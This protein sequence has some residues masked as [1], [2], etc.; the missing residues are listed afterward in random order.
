MIT[1]EQY[2]QTIERDKTRYSGNERGYRL[3]LIPNI[4]LTESGNDSDAVEFDVV[5][6][7]DVT[8]TSS[9]TTYPLVNGDVVADHM[10]RQ[11][12]SLT[13]SG[14]FALLGSRTTNF[15]GSSN[16]R[17]RNI[18]DYFEN[19]KNSGTLCKLVVRSRVDG[20]E[21]FKERNCV[22]L[23][24]IRWGEFQSSLSFTFTFD[25]IM[26]INVEDFD[27]SNEEL[28][29][30]D[31]NIPAITDGVSRSF[32]DEVVSKVDVMISLLQTAISYGIM[33]QEFADKYINDSKLIDELD[34]SQFK[35]VGWS[36][37]TATIVGTAIGGAAIITAGLV[38]GAVVGGPVGFVVGLVGGII[39]AIAWAV[40]YGATQDVKYAQEQ[41]SLTL[42]DY[43]NSQL[44]DEFDA[45]ASEVFQEIDILN[46]FNQFF[47]F[48]SNEAQECL[49]TISNDYYVFVISKN[50]VTE[51]W[52][53]IIE[54]VEGNDVGG[55]KIVMK[56]KAL[57]GLDEVSESSHI[58][59]SRGEGAFIYLYVDKV[60][61]IKDNKALTERERN[62]QLEEAYKDITNYGIIVSAA[63]GTKSS[64][65]NIGDKIVQIVENSLKR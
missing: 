11:P 15:S 59:R 46:E 44:V 31:P 60:A 19:L 34:S 49:L 61:G 41:F 26:L 48:T 64:L 35:D 43:K 42:D 57:P 32:T 36:Q 7:I 5:D 38:T 24:S 2:Y 52:E 51:D 65:L 8:S 37:Y 22:V 54:D 39:G 4:N 1:E 23:K 63:D 40:G 47:R 28:W 21:R 12:V 45:F 27:S 10:I 9:I 58:L 16:D 25:E 13:V 33:T 6:S 55:G 3:V 50:N 18:Q 56:S 30:I 62:I 14:K 29:N 53:L 17:L 20:V